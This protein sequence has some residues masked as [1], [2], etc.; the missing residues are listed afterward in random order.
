MQLQ[1]ICL[2]A[3]LL[4]LLILMEVLLITHQPHLPMLV[5]LMEI[6]NPISMAIRLLVIHLELLPISRSHRV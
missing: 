6:L 1:D 2:F 3:I 5:L 4:A